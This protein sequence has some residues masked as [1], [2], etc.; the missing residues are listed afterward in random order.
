MNFGIQIM[1]E[2][3]DN[4]TFVD[5]F[6]TSTNGDHR[7]FYNDGDMTFTPATTPFATNSNTNIQSAAVGD[8]NNDGFI[9]VIAGYANGFNSPSNINDQLFVNDGNEN[10]WTKIVLEGT[11]SNINGI[12]ARVEIYGEW[13][14]QVLSLIHI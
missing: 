9:D 6:M 12:G 4:D 13:G 7:L 14:M 8:V 3:F 1:M 10:N 5:F 11:V 2:D